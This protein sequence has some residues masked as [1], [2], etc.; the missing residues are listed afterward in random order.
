LKN[1]ITKEEAK[2]LFETKIRPML[3]PIERQRLKIYSELKM[4]TLQIAAI[5]TIAAIIIYNKVQDDSIVDFYFFL[6]T[7]AVTYYCFSINKIIKPYRKNFKQ[8]I[9]LQIFQGMIGPC[10]FTMEQYISEADFNESRISNQSYNR[11]HGEDFLEGEFLGQKFKFSEL[12]VTEVKKNG[13]NTST[14]IR[15]KGLFFIFKLPKDTKQNTL[16][17]K[18]D[19]EGFLGKMLGRTLQKAVSR[20]GYE[21]VQLESISFEKEF[22]VY[23]ND[24]IK[25]RVLLKPSVLE[26]LVQFKKKYK[27]IV[28]ISIRGEH[29]YLAVH[30]SK[31]HF[32]P[33]ITKESINMSEIREIYDL[34]L[35]TRDL[36]E[37]IDVT[38][39]A[40]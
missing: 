26:N 34:F 5:T 7:L 40:A 30:S 10:K 2:Q 20:K 39:E 16:I 18:D 32:E 9:L 33:N 24:Q 35:L 31:N 27:D 14:Y 23:S 19:E 11:Y 8:K 22:C 13:K 4:K 36:L 28:E 29:L 17:L 38:E 6:I 15:F 3:S 25:T 21:L 37:S 12:Y 1:L